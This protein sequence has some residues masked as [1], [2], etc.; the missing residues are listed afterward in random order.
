MVPLEWISRSGHDFRPDQ[1]KYSEIAQG[2][3][4]FSK[5][6]G[7]VFET[8]LPIPG[9]GWNRHSAGGAVADARPS[10]VEGCAVGA[11]FGYIADNRS[12]VPGNTRS[13][14]RRAEQARR[15]KAEGSVIG[16]HSAATRTSCGLGHGGRTLASFRR[17]EDAN[18]GHRGFGAVVALAPLSPVPAPGG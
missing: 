12:A 5:L 14:E 9:S 2:Y 11:A 15:T 6:R 4:G 16:Q 3:T 10:R 7:I 17:M 8:P 1:S 18:A 13:G